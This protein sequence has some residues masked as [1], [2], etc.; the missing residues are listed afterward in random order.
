M[1]SLKGCWQCLRGLRVSINPNE[2]H[3]AACRWIT[4]AIILHNLCVDV[5]GVDGMES[6]FTANGGERGMP[7]VVMEVNSWDM[8]L[9]TVHDETRCEQLINELHA[10]LAL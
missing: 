1:G 3:V 2:V 10:Y 6:F 7:D 4:I 5:E 9:D 8:P